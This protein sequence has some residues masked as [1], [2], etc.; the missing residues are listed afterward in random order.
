MGLALVAAA[1]ATE[2]PGVDPP[3]RQLYFPSG[4]AVSPDGRWLYVANANSDL[5]YNTGTLLALD[6]ARVG[7]TCEPDPT[8]AFA[9][10]C[11]EEGAGF[12]ADGVRVGTFAA[13]V[14]VSKDGGRLYVAVRSAPRSI[15]W[16]DLDPARN[17]PLDCGQER[18][19]ENTCGGEHVVDLIEPEPGGLA[20]G[21]PAEP[22]GLYV[23]E[24]LGLTPRLL[25]AHLSRAGVTVLD[26]CGGELRALDVSPALF[27]ADGRGQSGGFAVAKRPPED[28]EEGLFYVTSRT[29]SLVGSVLV[30]PPGVRCDATARVVPGPSFALTGLADGSDARGIAFFGADRAFIADREPPTLVEVDTTLEDGRPRNRSVRTVEVCPEPSVVRVDPASPSP[31]LFVVCFATSQIFVV[32][33]DL[34]QIV[35]VIAT[36]R[37]PSAL[38]FHPTEPRAFV[39]NFAENTVGIIDLAPESP[40]YR[41]M[42]RRLGKPEPLR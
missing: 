11:P 13:D 20:A 14:R 41:R 10:Y 23:H 34:M 40:T 2:S 8:N 38:E 36:G 33:G 18:F 3:E 21:L 1:C 30:D 32:D 31:V 6:L 4:M 35:D 12:V 27:P 42:I 25:V 5:R 26:D 29:S 39:T 17:E 19:D 22:F 24:A 9:D 7:P 15:T 16:I 28:A 37:G